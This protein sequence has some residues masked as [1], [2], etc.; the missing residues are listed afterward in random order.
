MEK[1]QFQQYV[2]CLDF[3]RIGKVELVW[4]THV[5]VKYNDGTW[6]D[7]EFDGSS[8][9]YHLHCGDMEYKRSRIVPIL[10]IT[11]HKLGEFYA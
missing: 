7:Y 4:E 5:T 3:D 1:W 9:S 2:Y 11:N 8:L 10:G 6:M